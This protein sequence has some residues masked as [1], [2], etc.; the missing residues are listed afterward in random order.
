MPPSN[1]S[2]NANHS[3]HHLARYRVRVFSFLFALELTLLCYACHSANRGI[4]LEIV[5]QLVASPNNLVIAACRT[6]E[7]ATALNDLKRSARGMIH[8]IRID[9]SDFDSIRASAKALQAVCGETG[10][11]YLI[12]NAGI[13]RALVCYPHRITL[14]HNFLVQIAD[15]T[16]ST[17]DPERLLELFKTNAAGPALVSQVCLPFLKKG[18]TKKILHI[19][20]T[21][22]SIGSLSALE[23]PRGLF[24]SYA[25]SKA[26]LNMLVCRSLLRPAT[27]L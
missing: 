13:V 19:S 12:N 16:V 2:D 15:D 9:V 21:A 11:D 1:D 25:M 4:G 26:A 23:S 18:S 6:P 20:S 17:L 22:G 8:I 27:S 7:K 3:S 24:T 14:I 5:T 10:L